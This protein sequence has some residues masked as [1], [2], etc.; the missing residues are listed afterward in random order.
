MKW[1]F[2]FILCFFIISFLG[3][4]LK[5]AWWQIV[6]AEELSHFAHSQ[7]ERPLEI[8]PIRGEIKTSDKFP[9]ASNR[10]SY[11]IFANPKEILEKDKTADIL[12][13]IL[14][15]EKATI[16]ALL[17]KD[18][19][20]VPL[21]SQVVTEDKTKIEKLTLPGIGFEEQTTRF[22]P[23]ASLAAQLLGFVGKDS[24]GN[25]KGYF[26]LEGYYD[27]QLK[28][29]PGQAIEI[30]DAFGRPILSKLNDASSGQQDGRT[31]VLHI[32]RAIQFLVEKKL[33]DGIEKYGAES[34][35]AVVMDPK[36]GSMLAMASFPSFDPRSFQDSA[37]TLYKNPLITDLYEPGSTFKP[38]IMSAALNSK[39]VTPQTTCP[40]CDGP[41][42]LGG[43]NLHTW[44]DKYYKNTSM[45]DVIIHSDNTGM[46]FVA[47]QLGLDRMLDY[48]ERFGI[49]GLTSIDLEG[50]AAPLLKDRNNW[51]PIDVATAGFGQ[52]LSI[53][54]IELLDAFSTIANDGVR[55][56]PQV[57]SSVITPD[58]Q[59]ISVPPK[60]LNYP[61]SSQT[62][63]V[64]TK[65]LIKSVDE[66][67]AKWARLKNYQIAGKTG[68]ASIPV[69]GHYDT[70]KT[71]A[72]FIGFAPAEN[73]KF[74]ML[75]ILNKPTASIYGAETAAP[76]F[77]DIARDILTYYGI[78]PT[79]GNAETQ[80]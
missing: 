25:D 32:D 64:M 63:H 41:V 29:R 67:E 49:G 23:E 35:M 52:G 65:I 55:M 58:G 4:I 20:W 40:I 1:R 28:G 30:H 26:G 57:V 73:P 79:G 9:L 24:F 27:R 50:E 71:I 56:Q 43:Y 45:I 74:V 17:A 72:S 6:D 34:G 78:A 15:E 44:N 16:S 46:V 31:L 61:I 70:T 69:N 54:P 51:Y 53:T 33:Q 38:L 14:Q 11:L 37:E 75:V 77:F 21:K 8:S 66:G 12:A 2:L 60:I 22:Y 18:L 42:S 59:T 36:T 76:I 10:L 19:F 39:V 62:A 68:T 47:Q 3:I 5:L 48:L 80:E 7:Y 13:P